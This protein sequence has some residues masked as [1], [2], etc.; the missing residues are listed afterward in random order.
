[1]ASA[2][3][4]ATGS[5]AALSLPHTSTTG[6]PSTAHDID[7]TSLPPTTTRAEPG[8]GW[9]VTGSL[10]KG[11]M[12]TTGL[13]AARFGCLAISAIHRS[14]SMVAGGIAS[15]VPSKSVAALLWVPA[16]RRFIRSHLVVVA[17]DPR[18]LRVVEPVRAQ[19][20]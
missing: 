13:H 14:R 3:S 10:V 2:T 11:L 9:K 1:S 4:T 7:P 19:V 5:T 17:L 16:V 6:E 8:C 18:L 20:G 12:P 15:T